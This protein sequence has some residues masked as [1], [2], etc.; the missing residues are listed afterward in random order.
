MSIGFWHGVSVLSN[1]C[2][3]FKMHCLT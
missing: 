3:N 1:L 2:F